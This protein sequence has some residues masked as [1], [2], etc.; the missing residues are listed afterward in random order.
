M[1]NVLAIALLRNTLLAFQRQARMIVAIWNARLLR[2]SLGSA[3]LQV[4]HLKPGG[5]GDH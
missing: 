1:L 3:A 2:R 4:T 5:V